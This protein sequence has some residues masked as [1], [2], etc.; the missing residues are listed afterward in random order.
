MGDY[1]EYSDSLL[2]SEK[3]DQEYHHTILLH[4]ESPV[5]SNQINVY[6]D[7]LQQKGLLQQIWKTNHITD[8]L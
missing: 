2:I 3:F 8:S 1:P 4:Q 6:L 7:K 5:T